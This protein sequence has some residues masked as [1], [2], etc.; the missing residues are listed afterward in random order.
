MHCTDA[1]YFNIID[2]SILFSFTS[3]PDFHRVVS[4]LQT[5]SL[6]KCFGY[7]RSFAFPC[8]L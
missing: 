5:C 3:S 4:I 7:S 2:S 6:C 1:I 8:E